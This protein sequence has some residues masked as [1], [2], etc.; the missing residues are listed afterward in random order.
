MTTV[1][2]V[3]N[4][5]RESEKLLLEADGLAFCNN[6]DGSITLD[7]Y[8]SK[9]TVRVRI[10]ADDARSQRDPLRRWLH[11]VKALPGA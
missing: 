5:K 2:R 1:H 4:G 3:S 9:Q 6:A 7:L 11:N 8:G 10:S